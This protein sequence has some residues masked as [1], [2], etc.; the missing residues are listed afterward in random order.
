MKLL[1][2]EF[3]AGDFGI[4]RLVLRKLNTRRNAHGKCGEGGA[5]GVIMLSS[6]LIVD[7]SRLYLFGASLK[8]LGKK[9]FAFTK[10]DLGEI[11]GIKAR[12]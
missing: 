2:A 5:N 10:L 8:D 3:S 12:I 9:C 11:A 1:S 7:D 4:I 6:V